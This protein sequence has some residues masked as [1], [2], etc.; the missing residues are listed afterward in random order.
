MIFHDSLQKWEVLLALNFKHPMLSSVHLSY[1][2]NDGQRE[3][4]ACHLSLQH[5]VP[6]H[7]IF[8]HFH[9]K[10]YYFNGAYISRGNS[11][12]VL[13]AVEDIAWTLSAN[14]Y[15]SFAACISKV[16]SCHMYAWQYRHGCIHQTHDRSNM[17]YKLLLSQ[18]WKHPHRIVLVSLFFAG[19]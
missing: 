10:N 19:I 5:S 2:F 18:K 11:M 4:Q 8:F 7:L 17:P 3:R 14:M 6:L 13:Y 12:Y 9:I 16:G 15:V 1:I